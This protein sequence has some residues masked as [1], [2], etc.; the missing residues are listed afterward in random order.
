MLKVD[1]Q[2]CFGK[3]QQEREKGTRLFSCRDPK[4]HKKTFFQKNVNKFFECNF[5]VKNVFFKLL[6]RSLMDEYLVDA[7]TSKDGESQIKCNV[8]QFAFDG[9]AAVAD[10]LKL[11]VN[12]PLHINGL[13]NCCG[14]S[15]MSLHDAIQHV[16]FVHPQSHLLKERIDEAG[17]QIMDPSPPQQKRG[18]LKVCHICDKEFRRPAD[19][20]RHMRVHTG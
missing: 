1:V 20:V 19:L 3:L 2:R 5:I 8:C 9:N 17:N 6:M 14:S 18:R 16:L 10:H 11:H 15:E 12:D 4:H 13:Y 7:G